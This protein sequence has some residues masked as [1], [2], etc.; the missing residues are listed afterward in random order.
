MNISTYLDN[1]LNSELSLQGK[2][3]SKIELNDTL[4]TLRNTLSS[5]QDH[6][7]CYLHEKNPLRFSLLFFLLLEKNCSPIPLPAE[8]SAPLMTLINGQ[9]NRAFIFNGEIKKNG[10]AAKKNGTIKPHYIC[11]TSGSTG[12]PKE[13]ILTIEGAIENAKEHAKSLG[14]TSKHTILQNLPLYHSFGIVAYL[15]VTAIHKCAL[16]FSPIFLTPK[17]MK[18]RT[19]QNCV[20]HCSPS[21]LNFMLKEKDISIEGVS[22]VSF[23]AGVVSSANVLLL[24]TTFP[25]ARFYVTYG[26][27]ELG[28]RVTTGE[29]TQVMDIGYIGVPFSNIK[30]RV[31]TEEKGLVCNGVGLLALNSPSLKNNIAPT[32]I[33]T[34]GESKFFLTQDLVK[35]APS[36]EIFFLS[37]SDDLIKVGGISV[38]AIDI[39]ETAKRFKGVLDAIVLPMPHNVYGDVPVLFV[40]GQ[41]DLRELENYLS[42]ELTT[43]QMPKKVFI[44]EALPRISINKI[45]RKKLKEEYFG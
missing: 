14:I 4:V 7:E 13:C 30:A 24:K 43:Y 44:L 22:I 41:V 25:E 27:T 18:K 16:E 31:Y 1:F 10:L 17:N 6:T 20:L 3:Y 45:D 38:Y 42:T 8:I 40:E 29:I 2:P 35:I 9:L 32:D 15:F 19:W 21:Q 37:R 39:E 36:G 28:P 33:I 12:N 34:E 23:G 5:I 26:L 11:M